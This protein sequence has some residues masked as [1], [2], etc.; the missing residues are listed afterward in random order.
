MYVFFE[1]F[2]FLFVFIKKNLNEKR[3]DFCE[4][5]SINFIIY[6]VTLLLS[7]DLVF[8]WIYHIKFDYFLSH[9]KYKVSS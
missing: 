7:L 9:I 3:K 1:S 5:F 6:M 4:T 8:Y 2:L